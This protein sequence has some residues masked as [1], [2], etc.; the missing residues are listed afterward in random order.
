[1]SSLTI[2]M[3]DILEKPVLNETSLTNH[4][5]FELLWDEKKSGEGV[6]IE[7]T[8][9]LRERLGLELEPVKRVVELLEV[10]VSNRKADR[11]VDDGLKRSSTLLNAKLIDA[12]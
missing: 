8:R 2:S 1:M 7:L 10:T 6:P 4:Y 5:D 3:D 12:Q 9:A 11:S